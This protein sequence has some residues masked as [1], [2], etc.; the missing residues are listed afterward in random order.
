RMLW[1]EQV[2]DVTS[3]TRP[4]AE[5]NDPPWHEARVR[6]RT[7]WVTRHHPEPGQAPANGVAPYH[8]RSA[9]PPR[10]AR[11]RPPRPLGPPRPAPAWPPAGPARAP[12]AA[13]SAGRR[14]W[15][16]RA[17]RQNCRSASTV[18]P[19]TVAGTLTP[20]PPGPTRGPDTTSLNPRFSRRFRG[21][22]RA[23]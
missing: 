19:D 9:G 17:D 2:G 6:P 8:A 22:V 14:W 21:C 13:G 4:R 10:P 16:G 12:G 7:P 15:V 23:S 18:P 3:V 5:G 11:G 1:K 20:A